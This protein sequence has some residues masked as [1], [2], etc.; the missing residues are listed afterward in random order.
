[1]FYSRN[2]RPVRQAGGAVCRTRLG[3]EKVRSDR[4]AGNR[5]A[6]DNISKV[7]AKKVFFKVY[8]TPG[9]QVDRLQEWDGSEVRPLFF[10]SVKCRFAK[11][12]ILHTMRWSVIITNVYLPGNLISFITLAYWLLTSNAIMSWLISALS[13]NSASRM[14]VSPTTTC[15]L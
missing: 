11:S 9:S 2:D 10:E 4:P 14:G 5:P 3:F 12:S 1:M 6:C 15:L 13:P 7:F 8:R